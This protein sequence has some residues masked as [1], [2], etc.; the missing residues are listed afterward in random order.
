MMSAIVLSMRLQS[1]DLPDMNDFLQLARE[2]RNAA[3]F[4]YLQGER[5]R[6]VAFC[7]VHSA[8]LLLKGWLQQQGL[9]SESL[10][11]THDLQVLWDSQLATSANDRELIEILSPIDPKT[12]R[13]RYP[14]TNLG[15][16]NLEEIRRVVLALHQI[17]DE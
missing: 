16:W 10:R 13:F 15:D 7:Y 4:L 6:P 9:L 8:E 5:S 17:A 14:S 2:S 3:E 1:I 11:K 12:T